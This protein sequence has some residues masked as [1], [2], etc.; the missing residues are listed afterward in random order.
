MTTETSFGNLFLRFVLKGNDFGWVGFFNVCP[1]RAMTR[2]AAGYLVL[3][4]SNL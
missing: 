2:F 3:P 4:T 1:A